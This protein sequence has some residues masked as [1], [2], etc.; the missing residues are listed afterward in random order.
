MHHVE[1]GLQAVGPPPAKL[2]LAPCKV[3]VS[4]GRGQPSVAHFKVGSRLLQVALRRPA[5]ALVRSERG[6]PRLELGDQGFQPAHFKTEPRGLG[7]LGRQ[8]V[9]VVVGCGGC[10][11]GGVE[12]LGL[13]L[14]LGP[15]QLSKLPLQPGH[16]LGELLVVLDER[17]LAHVAVRQRRCKLP[18]RRCQGRSGR[19]KIVL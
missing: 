2:E 1:L 6:K 8:R 18:L 5:G 3:K 14:G 19:S 15:L 10:S 11:G 4:H 12:K 17:S 7:P 9:L 16:A 13:C